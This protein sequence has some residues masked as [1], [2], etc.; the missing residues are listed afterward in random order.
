[1]S[2]FYKKLLIEIGITAGV[3]A[4]LG[5]FILFFSKNINSKTTEI[6]ATRTELGNWV[7]SVQSLAFVRS[8]Y[9]GKAR[10]YINVLQS[11]LPTKDEL[12]DLKKDFQFI[13]AGEDLNLRFSFIGEE[14]TGSEKL[15]AIGIQLGLDGQM[16]SVLNFIKKL[17]SFKYLVSIDSI[18]TMEKEN[19]SIEANVR[20][21]V[22]FRK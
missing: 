20:A 3:V 14:Q 21:K 7:S 4:V 19:G 17:D 13:A 11:V 9:T 8:E 16:S 6:E 1:M 10:D 18:N 12:I 15:G 2:A 5:I 22:Y